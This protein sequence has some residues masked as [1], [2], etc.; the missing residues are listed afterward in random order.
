MNSV[1]LKRTPLPTF[2]PVVPFQDVEEVYAGD[3]CALFGIDCA[4]GDTFTSRTSSNLSMVSDHSEENCSY[5]GVSC[6]SCA[7]Y[8]MNVMF[9]YHSDPQES[10]HVP[11][12]VISMAIKPANKVTNTSI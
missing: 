5:S 12:P 10:I 2:P 8:N 3:I 9:I 11:E 1:P 7:Q 4:S 6:V